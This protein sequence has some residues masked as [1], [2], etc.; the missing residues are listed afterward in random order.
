MLIWWRTIV[1]RQQICCYKVSKLSGPKFVSQCWPPKRIRIYLRVL[2][3]TGQSPECN[4]ASHYDAVYGSVSAANYVPSVSLLQEKGKNPLFCQCVKLNFVPVEM[5]KPVK[6]RWFFF[7]G[8]V[9]PQWNICEIFEG[10]VWIRCPQAG[11]EWAGSFG[12]LIQ[13]FCK[14][15]IPLLPPSLLYIKKKI[16]H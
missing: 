4:E 3:C 9:K 1:L 15:R 5:R 11:W 7:S 2:S 14:L 16:N 12:K 10:F 13:F 8:L 6:G